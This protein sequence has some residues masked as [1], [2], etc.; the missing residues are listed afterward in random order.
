MIAIENAR[1]LN[2]LRESLEQQTA[3]SEVL[4][5]ISS[6]PGDLEPVFATMLEKAVRICDAKFGNLWLREGDFLRIGATHGAPSAWSEFLRRDPVVR[7][8]PR[9][10]T[11]RAIAAKQPYQVADVAA[12][13]TYGD[14]VRIATIELARARSLIGVPLLR[15]DEVIGFI[16]IYRQEVRPFTDKQ[17]EVVQNFAAQAVIAIENARLLNELRESLQQQTATSEV[18]RV[19]SSSPGEL[20]PAFQAMLENATRICEAKFGIL[21]LCERQGF[22]CAALHSAPRAFAEQFRSQP[23]V[24]PPPGSGLGRL[25]ETRQVTH[26][27]DMAATQAYIERRSPAIVAAVELGGVRTHVHVPMLKENSLIGAITVYRQEVRPFTDKQIE[28]IEN[29]A[30]Q[31]VIAIENTRLLNELRES[32]QQQTATADVLKVISRSTFDLPRVLNTLLESA[33]HLCEADKGV[34]LRPREDRS[35]Y[36][37]AIYRHTPEFVESQKGIL[38][39][40]GR[41]GVVGRVLLEGKSVQVPD[42]L[43]DPEYV[44]LEYAKTRRLSYKPGHTAFARGDSGWHTPPAACERTSVYGQADR[45][46]RD[47][48][49]PGGDRDREHPTVR[50][51]AAA[52]AGAYRI[53]GTA[54]GYVKSARCYEPLSIRSPCDI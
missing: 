46:G 35:Y 6:S 43:N 11:A 36:A 15:D 2:E 32:L 33:A 48:R 13:P 49:R 53:A 17:I 30:N 34:I 18:L 26:V 10:G 50:G 7:I 31:A 4:Q 42:V 28:L 8:D 9:L 5:V 1:L 29:F 51:R 39:E 21:W 20:E 52:H 44:Y 41:G 14:K 27:A 23:V 47:L 45:A 12:E 40:P 3:T 25:A 22:R 19:I 24:H 16:V 37:A 38:F 54:D